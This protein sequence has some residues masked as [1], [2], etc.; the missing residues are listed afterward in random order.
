MKE[1]DVKILWGRSGNRCAIC[2]IELTTVGSK[3]VLGEMAHIIADS[4]QGPRGKSHLTPEQ[5]DEYDNLI[6]L[7]PTHHTLIDKGEDEWTVEKLKLIKSQHENWVSE[8]LNQNKIS[9]NSIDNSKFLEVQ[10][11]E[12]INYAGNQLWV[13]VSLT[14]LNIYDDIINPLNSELFKLINSLQLPQFSGYYSMIHCNLNPNITRPNENGIINQELPNKHSRE[15]GHKIQ[16]FR[17]GHC[18]FLVCL[19]YVRTGTNGSNNILRYE[20]MINSFITQTKGILNIWD[21][22]LPFNDMLLTVMMTN[23]NNI[24]LYSGQQTYMGN[25]LIG[26]PINSPTL[27]Y[28]RIINKTEDVQSLQ[29]LVIKRFV[30]YFGLN[31]EKV[32]AENGN[33]YLPNRLH[34]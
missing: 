24:S 20:D 31:I 10:E 14:P 25:Y 9:I 34:F 6:L 32:F 18:E 11:K 22:S 3:S 27:K 2:K 13:I 8:Q 30:N 19:E 26:D 17:N 15:L 4:P 29:E 28:S 12:W 16:I 23:T 21:S 7:C 5:R 1:K 33:F